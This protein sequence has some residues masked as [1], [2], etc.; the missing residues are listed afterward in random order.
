MMMNLKLEIKLG[1][2]LKI[3]PQLKLIMDKYLLKMK[4]PQVT[5]VCKVTIIKIE[6]FDEAMLV[7]QVQIGKFGVQEY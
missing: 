2:L 7:V 4:E 5:S 3:F 1:Q 6:D